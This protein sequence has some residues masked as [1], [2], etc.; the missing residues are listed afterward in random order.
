[1]QNNAL[2]LQTSAHVI[3]FHISLD[4]CYDYEMLHL[5]GSEDTYSYY[6][7]REWRLGDTW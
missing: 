7:S 2:V 4:K 1:M 5:K 6:V 3:S